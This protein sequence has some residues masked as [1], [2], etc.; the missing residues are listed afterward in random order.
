[1]KFECHYFGFQELYTLF[2]F[3]PEGDAA[4]RLCIEQLDATGGTHVIQEL[5]EFK[6]ENAK[7]YDPNEQVV[8]FSSRPAFVLVSALMFIGAG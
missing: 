7:C 5:K 2:A 1:M 3:A 4:K 8:I 6:V